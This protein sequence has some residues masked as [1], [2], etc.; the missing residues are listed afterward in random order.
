MP[1]PSASPIKVIR[2]MDRL[3]KYMSAKVATTDTG[4]ATAI[5]KVEARLFKK[6]KRIATA[7]KPP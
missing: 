1:M 5:I 3:P 2:L 6:K 4:T 7:N